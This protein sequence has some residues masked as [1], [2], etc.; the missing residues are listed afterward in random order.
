MKSNLEKYLRQMFTKSES[1]LICKH[2]EM[3]KLNIDDVFIKSGIIVDK[4]GFIDEG[5]LRVV[6]HGAKKERIIHYFYE[7][8]H[9]CSES[10]GYY[11]NELSRF[12]LEAALPCT[13]FTISFE[14]ME[15]L[16]N[17]IPTFELMRTKVSEQSLVN[18]ARAQEIPKKR[19][20]QK[21]YEEF[22]RQYPSFAS[23][24]KVYDVASYLG[25]T[26]NHL[27]TIRNKL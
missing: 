23:K 24:L 15:M 4:V 10:N 14:K 27:S 7:E 26:P 22:L 17:K 2:F 19:N 18:I 1:V 20:A 6:E 8:N 16:A 21:R 12:S 3:V 13:I 9:F 25:I 5:V 11:M